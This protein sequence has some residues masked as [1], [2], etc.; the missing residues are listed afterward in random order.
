MRAVQLRAA[1]AAAL[2]PQRDRDIFFGHLPQLVG[3][4]DVWHGPA[5]GVRLV[6]DALRRPHRAPELLAPRVPELCDETCARALDRL[7]GALE[8]LFVPFVI[9]SDDRAMCERRRID[10]D[11][12]GDNRPAA[13]LGAFGQEVGPAIGDAMA[14]PVVCQ[15]RR[16]HDAIAQGAL[17]DFQ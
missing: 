7:R 15:R 8:T 9:A 13:A 17:A 14:R 4:H 10:R 3:G 12:L 16:E 11:D 2:E 5:I 6:R 1:E